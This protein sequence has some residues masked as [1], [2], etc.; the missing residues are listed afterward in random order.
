[1]PIIKLIIGVKLA[2]IG[3]NTNKSKLNNLAILLPQLIQPIF[4]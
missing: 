4:S 2:A 1:M 3:T